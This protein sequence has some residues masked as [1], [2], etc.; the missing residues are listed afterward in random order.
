VIWSEERERV[1]IV[2][3]FI[4]QRYGRV[5]YLESY[6]WEDDSFGAHTSFQPQIPD[7]SE[8]DL[9]LGLF[10][11]RI[12][13]PDPRLPTMPHVLTS[14]ETTPHDGFHGDESFPGGAAYEVLHALELHAC[15]GS[16]DVYIFRRRDDSK[17]NVSASDLEELVNA[18]TQWRG[19]ETF[20]ERWFERRDGTKLRAYESYAATQGQSGPDVFESLLRKTLHNWMEERGFS[21]IVWPIEELGTPF[22]GLKVFDFHHQ[23]IFFGRERKKRRAYDLLRERAKGFGY[24]EPVPDHLVG[25]QTGP[26]RQ[27]LPFLLIFGASGAGKSSFMRAGI[28]PLV[29]SPGEIQW[30]IA[31]MPTPGASNGGPAL[32]LARALF[33]E[34][35]VG[36]DA[37]G[38]GPALPEL[39]LVGC[40][41]AAALAQLFTE[42]A[43]ERLR[44][45]AN[46]IVAALNL[47]RRDE[48]PQASQSGAGESRLLILVDQLEEIFG[49]SVGELEREAFPLLLLELM[50]T[51]RVWVVATLR[52]DFYERML[53]LPSFMRL[54]D[55]GASYDLAPPGPDEIEEIIDQSAEATGLIYGT[56]PVTGERLDKRLFAD[57]AGRDVLPLLEFALEQMFEEQQKRGD[58]VLQFADYEKIGGLA[59]AI[60]LAASN[61]YDRLGPED[62]Q[63]LPRILR[64]LVEPKVS[65][66]SDESVG[67]QTRFSLRFADIADV[68]RSPQARRLVDALVSARVVTAEMRAERPGIS[69]D[70]TEKSGAGEWQVGR[71]RLA[72]E[73][74]I[75]A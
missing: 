19:V 74:V 25:H 44:D 56:H 47:I 61:A 69:Q 13:F 64:A 20:F 31:L 60:D 73:R 37:G 71:I 21:P 32:A 53:L 5:A 3:N 59:G 22:R 72:H 65:Y 63:E 4:N 17:P 70:A 49:P 41:D 62:Q 15:T 12:G 16:P 30:R 35:G 43:P 8:F 58:L 48:G 2:V 40:T 75:R 28:A 18:N 27:A 39:A 26:D 10:W 29:V 54:K 51:G 11:S 67:E 52:A 23:S 34:H 38:F 1:R 7:V 68:A 6:L 50:E 55:T 45:T 33:E 9:V 14:G 24:G 57:A 36:E 46:R 42:T 66:A